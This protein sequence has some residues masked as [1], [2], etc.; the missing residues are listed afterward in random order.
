MS[1]FYPKMISK[2]LKSVWTKIITTIDGGLDATWSES[3][4]NYS[5]ADRKNIHLS[6]QDVDVLFI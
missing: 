1:C 3:V 4:N 2:F 5:F 6:H